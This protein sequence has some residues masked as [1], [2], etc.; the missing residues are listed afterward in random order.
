VAVKP[1]AALPVHRLEV[2]TYNQMVASGALEGQPV[3]LLHG[4]V[5]DMSPQSPSHAAAIE[6]LTTHFASARARVR[7]QLPL[8]VPPDSEPEPDLALV[9]ERPP[10]GRHPRTALLVI[11][12]AVNSH[13]IDRGVKSELY[14][15][16]GV[17]LYWLIDVPRRA[18]EVRT[19]PAADGYEHCDTYREGARVPAPI[20]GV[21]GLDI[22]A[23]LQDAGEQA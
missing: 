15:R 2:E 17:P 13:A 12:V 16:A 19:R 11:E 20:D 9:A 4:I 5:V 21:E 23:L 14:A 10:A 22:A 3:E 7:V 1:A 8:E 6:A 18:V